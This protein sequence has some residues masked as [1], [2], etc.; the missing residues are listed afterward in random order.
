MDTARETQRA[1]RLRYASATT[2]ASR[3]RYASAY[4]RRLYT[5]G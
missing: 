4:P 3:L 1:S 5:P 2:H